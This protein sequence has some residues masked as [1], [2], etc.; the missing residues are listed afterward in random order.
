MI[1]IFLFFFNATISHAQ[2]TPLVLSNKCAKGISSFTKVNGIDFRFPNKDLGFVLSGWLNTNSKV[3][4]KGN[5]LDSL[6]SFFL[7]RDVPQA[8]ENEIAI[9]LYDFKLSEKAEEMKNTSS[10]KLALRV[11]KKREENR[12]EEIFVIDTLYRMSSSTDLT[13]KF[14]KSISEHLCEVAV[15][16]KKHENL[17]VE[18]GPS[19]TFNEL[20]HL[21]SL[22]KMKTPI[23]ITDKYKA[24]IYYDFNQFKNNSPDTTTVYIDSIH[25]DKIRVMVWND[26]KGKNVELDNKTVY[27]VCDG[28]FLL[29]ATKMGFY[30]LKREKFD[31][32]FIGQTEAKYLTN[33]K[34]GSPII[35]SGIGGGG[36]GIGIGFSVF[37]TAKQTPILNNF[38]INYRTG[39]TIQTDNNNIFIGEK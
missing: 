12:F 20:Q 29:K 15:E 4:C 11:F 37:T 28:S 13:K 10:L 38:K 33:D 7:N 35:G 19:Y 8:V 5:F 23:Y 27:A 16:L 14:L 6:C 2:E 18:N 39:K 21:D 34:N 17:Q 24:G 1:Y 22:E 31:F 32:Y 3:E 9:V 25:T 30:E 36:I 26:E